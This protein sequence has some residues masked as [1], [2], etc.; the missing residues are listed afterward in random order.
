M[1]ACVVLHNCKM[2]VKVTH[3]TNN[4]NN[5]KNTKNVN[6]DFILMIEALVVR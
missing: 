2:F 4:N 6:H 3:H 5:D 1:T